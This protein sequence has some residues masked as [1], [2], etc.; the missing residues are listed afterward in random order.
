MI[1]YDVVRAVLHGTLAV[2]IFLGPVPIWAIVLI[3]ACFG[4]AEAF[5]NPAATG[6]VPRPC[7]RASSSRP[8]PP[9]A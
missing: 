8:T 2:L 3:E 6:L 5:F 1:A 9:P 7:P 4:Q